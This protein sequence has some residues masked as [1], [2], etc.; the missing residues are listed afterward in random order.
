MKDAMR[1]LL[2]AMALVAKVMAIS[3]GIT[4]VLAGV[5]YVYAGL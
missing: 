5:F 3:I 4:L 1:E 2:S